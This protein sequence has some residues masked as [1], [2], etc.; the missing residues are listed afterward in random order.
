M[1]EIAKKLYKALNDQ[2]QQEVA[3][4][5]LYLSM[6]IHCEAMNLKGAASWL[7]AQWDEELTHAL[8]L[9]DYVNSR[10]NKVALQAIEKPQGQFKSLLDVFETVLSHERKVSE[11]INR[12][13]GLA[14]KEGD[15]AAQAFLQ[16]FVSEQVEEE[17]TSTEIVEMI[18]LAGDRGSA[19]L[20]VDR[21]L[22]GRDSDGDGD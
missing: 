9:V 14:V 5:Y 4:A 1:P 8:K 2:I 21:Q 22:A 7:R 18:R 13:Y 10:G 19:I 11:S 6:S 20:M 3:S 16:W 15:F 12:L 17:A